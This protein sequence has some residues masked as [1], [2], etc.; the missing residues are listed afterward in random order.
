MITGAMKKVLLIV[1]VLAVVA[2]VALFVVGSNLDGI[3]KQAVETAGP[4]ITQTSVTLDGV[5]LSPR[6]GS[7]AIKGL[8]IGN[9]G[10]Y[11]SPYAIKLGE[12]KLEIDPASVLSD[13]I[14]VKSIAVTD[15]HI[16][17]EGGFGD[18]NLKKILANIDSFTAGEKS[19]AATGPGPKKKLQVDDFLLSGAKVD[20]KFALLGGKPLSVTLPD[21]HLTNLGSGGEGITP[22]ELSKRVFNAVLEQVIPAVTAQIGNLGGLGKDLGKGA[23]DKA[24]GGL[25]DL[26]KKK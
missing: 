20:V 17:I 22:G 6:S 5:G 21:I 3:V 16:T 11:S 19:G 24:A 23:L 12:A 26:F 7:G 10:G 4:K 9:P 15:P 13:K 18:N 14:H 8:T 2:V 25:G 1:A